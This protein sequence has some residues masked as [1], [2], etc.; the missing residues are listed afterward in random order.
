MSEILSLARDCALAA[1]VAVL[2]GAT[3]THLAYE[4][5][6]DPCPADDPCP[7]SS[8]PWLRGAIEKSCARAKH[9]ALMREANPGKII[10]A[11][12]CKHMCDPKD[13]LA[14]ETNDRRWDVKC[15]AR[16]NPN[17]CV[18]KHPCEE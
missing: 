9:V 12:A 7:D 10:L 5:A 17:G 3:P 6:V 1:L 11:C 2:L 18:C 8:R 15:Q 4:Q 16:C 14:K 13:P